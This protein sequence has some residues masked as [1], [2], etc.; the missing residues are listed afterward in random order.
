LQNG[1][2]AGIIPLAEA[3][4][5]ALLKTATFKEQI[6]MADR[7]YGLDRGESGKHNAT[8]VTESASSPTKDVEVAVDLAVNLTK[9]EVA[10]ILD[11]IKNYILT[12]DINIV[13]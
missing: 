13:E 6:E 11:Q 1:A 7:F 5:D 9:A 2:H 10:E 12:E 4:E 8:I 3:F